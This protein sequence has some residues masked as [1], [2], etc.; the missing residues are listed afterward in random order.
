MSKIITQVSS[1]NEATSSWGTPVDIGAQAENVLYNGSNIGAAMT[2]T[3]NNLVSHTGTIINQVNGVHGLRYYDGNLQYYDSDEEDW[4]TIKTGGS[5]MDIPLGDVSNA[6]AAVS[7]TTATIKWT[8]P[9]DVVISGLTIT[10]W[11]GTK[12]V[13]KAGSE[14][15]SVSD[16]TVV[17]NSTTRNQYATSG[18]QDTGLTLNTVYYYRF[19]PYSTENTHTSG[20]SV[21][22]APG[23]TRISTVPTQNTSTPLTY[24]GNSRTPVWNNY[25]SSQLSIGGISSATNAGTYTATFTPRDGYCWD[26]YSMTAKSVEWTISKANRGIVLKYTLAGSSTAV[27]I[28]SNTT[29]E[30][31]TN[32]QSATLTATGATTGTKSQSSS[33]TNYATINS[34]WVITAGASEGTTNITVGIAETANYLAYSMTFKAKMT[35]FQLVSFSSGTDAQIAAMVDA[36][37]NGSCT[38]AD[39]QSVWSVGD[40]RTIT[41]SAMSATGVGESHRSQSV[42]M[43]ILDF[44]HDTLATSING[45]TKALITVQQKNCLR[46]ASVSDTN[47]SAN[48]EH[49]YMNS[50]NTNNGGWRSCARRTWCNNVYYAALPSGFKALVKEATHQTTAGN[51]SSTMNTDTDKCFLPSEWEVFGATTYAKAQEGTQYEYYKTAANRYKLPK[52]NSSSVSDFWWERSP[53]GSSTT[54]FCRVNLD[55]IADNISASGAFGLAPACCI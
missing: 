53:Y 13:R 8:D 55:G 47:G 10:T 19:F 42:E 20:S 4:V 44:D 6:T 31:T 35:L 39:I 16:G 40:S 41:L 7:S 34:N 36:Y 12:V 2:Q 24:T 32:V 23:Y 15:T 52:W 30:L 43:V 54:A 18:F 17:V 25:S 29:I 5:S 3:S 22:V 50:S 38:L 28:N 14:P 9:D 46:D 27:T 1:Y 51:Q 21:V 45:K 37:Y 11:A 49:G 26:D 33:N 48:T